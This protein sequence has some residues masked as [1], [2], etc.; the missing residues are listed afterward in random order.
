MKTY[1]AYLENE[2]GCTFDDCESNNKDNVKK[3]ARGRGGKYKLIICIYDG[4]K[5]L[6]G[7][8]IPTCIEHYVVSGDRVVFDYA[9]TDPRS[10]R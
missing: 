5:D 10:Y 8:E 2:Q 1:K 7:G 9:D 4:V 6:A 3:W